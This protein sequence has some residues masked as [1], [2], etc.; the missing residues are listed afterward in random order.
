MRRRFFEALLAIILLV[1]FSQWMS[2]IPPS[3]SGSGYTSV[4]PQVLVQN[5]GLYEN[6]SLTTSVTISNGYFVG[7]DTYYNS[8]ENLL[9]VFRFKNPDL[10]NGDRIQIR[11]V[12]LLETNGFFVVEEFHVVDM[13]SSLIRSFP[14]IVLFAILFFMVFSFDLQSFQFHVRGDGHS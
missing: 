9:V 1:L 8:V 11:G 13:S 4:N 12:S 10:S 7:N 2:T 6:H 5:P 14:G 3:P